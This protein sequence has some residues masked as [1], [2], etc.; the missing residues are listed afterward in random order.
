[1]ATQNS[2]SCA[3][4]QNGTTT[5]HPRPPYIPNHIPDPNYIRILDTT[6]RDGE[7]APGA[8][9]TSEQKLEL[10]RQIVK[11]GVDIIDVGFPSASKDDFMAVKM[12]AQEIGNGEYEDG[13]VPV[14]TC[15]CRCNENDITTAWEAVKYAKRPRLITFIAT[16]PIHMEYKLKK[17]KEQVLE[18]APKMVKFARSL[19]CNDIQFA[20]ED[21]ARSD[22]E[23][24]Y[25]IFGEVIKAGATTLDIPDT[26]GIMMPCEY[27]KLI[28]DIKANTPGIHNV[29]IATHCHNDLGVATADTLQVEEYSGLHLQPHKALV[30]ANAFV[31]ESGIHQVSYCIPNNVQNFY[32]MNLTYYTTCFSITNIKVKNKM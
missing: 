24:L 30:G 27:G 31:H 28:A 32:V 10:A 9:M 8:A 6:L 2:I 17:T 14:I 29:I 5:P 21:A 26:V 15:I 13:Y 1:M 4:I 7:Q 23:F 19:G 16:S 18:I 20:A 12:I 25:Q 11:L 22:R 3:Q